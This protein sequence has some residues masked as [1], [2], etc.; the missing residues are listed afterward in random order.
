MNSIPHTEERHENHKLKVE[1]LLN[2]IRSGM[3]DEE[4]L[5][6]HYITLL[7]LEKLENNI[8]HTD[9][10]ALMN[11]H[12]S[13]QDETNNS[14][15]ENQSAA[16]NDESCFICPSCLEPQST[17]F[18]ICPRCSVS[19]Q[20]TMALENPTP[21]SLSEGLAE[22][23]SEN[24]TPG[25]SE[26][27]HGDDPAAVRRDP[28]GAVSFSATV[29]LPASAHPANPR[30]KIVRTNHDR[31]SQS[32]RLYPKARNTSRAPADSG[33]EES[34]P[35]P[36]VSGVRCDS[37]KGRMAPAL[38]D[39][40]DRS[41]SLQSLITAA[42][43]FAIGFVGSVSLSFMDAPSLGR[44]TVFFVTGIVILGG[45]VFWSVGAFMYMAREKVYFC[46]RCKRSYPRADISYLAAAVTW[47]S[48]RTSGG[49]G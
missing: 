34:K 4:L 37:C 14:D 44:L 26:A 27:A 38:R 49:F 10:E 15:L 46:P 16:G 30:N 31:T 2:D 3:K 20:E 35:V 7:K 36:A 9:V 33:I 6:K 22:K 24:P 12:V 45:V 48:R 8:D 39:I 41:R 42:I 28:V 25:L 1:D 13:F 18:D 21:N 5:R 17:L 32:S 40:Y 29:E 43:C 19:V 47:S 11:S 23:I